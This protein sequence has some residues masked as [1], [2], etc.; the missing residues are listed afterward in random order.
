[1]F[2]KFGSEPDEYISDYKELYKTQTKTNDNTNVI[3]TNLEQ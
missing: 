1:M 3:P 2:D